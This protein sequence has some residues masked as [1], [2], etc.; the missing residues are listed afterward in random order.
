MR[1]A[2]RCMADPS[3]AVPIAAIVVPYVGYLVRGAMLFIQD[4]RGMAGTGLVLGIAAACS[5]S[6]VV[7]PRCDAARSA[8]GRDG[9]WGSRF[10][11]QPAPMPAR[12]LRV[13]HLASG[14]VPI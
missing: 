5:R 11:F 14:V 8:A 10:S 2:D 12:H 1:A 7:R 4:P 6:A 13:G 9:N 3:A